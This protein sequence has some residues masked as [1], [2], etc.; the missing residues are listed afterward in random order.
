[1]LAPLTATPDSQANRPLLVEEPISIRVDIPP[2]D[3]WLMQEGLF[4]VGFFIDHEFVSEEEHG[5]VPFT[6]P[7]DPAGLTPG[8]HLLTVNV[9]GFNGKVAAKSLLFEVADSLP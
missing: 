2:P 3:R 7:L 1:M 5:Y 6:W 8:L 4:E 9:S